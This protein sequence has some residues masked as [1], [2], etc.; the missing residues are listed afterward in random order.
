[1]SE[2]ITEQNRFSP[3]TGV[4]PTLEPLNVEIEDEKLL[5]YIKTLEEKAK[6][7]WDSE[8]VNL[9]KRRDQNFKYLFGKQLK[10]KRLK[11]YESEYIDNTIY[12]SEGILKSLALSKM[13][14]III[15][16][17]EF[18][19]E[20][21]KR[22]ADLLT[23]YNDNEINKLELKKQL[24]I[25]FKHLPVYLIS[26]MKYRWDESKGKF[27]SFIQEVVHPEHLLLDHTAL[28]ANPD[29]ME[30]VVQY[31]EKSGKE[32]AMLFPKKEQ[33][34]IDYIKGKHSGL[35]D[36][37][38]EVV[39][40][41]K[42]R[43]AEVWFD[44]FDKAED[45]DPEKPKFNF[46]SGVAWKLS[47]DVLLGKSKNPNWDYEGHSVATINGS[48][49]APE[50]IQQLILTGQQP[51]G[52][53]IKKVFNNYFDFPRKPFIFMSYDQFLM[54]AIDETSRIEQIVPIQ[55]SVDDTER[56]LD[57]MVRTSKGKNIFSK[58]SGMKAKDLEKL[59]LNDP[60]KDLLVNGV[61]SQVHSFIP[62]V[63]PPGEMFV[64]A[65]DKRDRIFAKMGV[66]GAT[67]GEVTTSTATTNQISREAD[68]NKSDDIVDETILHVVTELAKARLH[69]MKLR[70]TADHFKKILGAQGEDLHFQLTNDSIEDG[71]EVIVSAS[72]TDKLKAERNAQNMAQLN[73][74]DPLT[75]F[76]DLGLSD[77]EGR[78]ERLFLKETN[79][80]MY[81]QKYILK[82]DLK[83]IANTVIQ[84]QTIP[85]AGQ[86]QPMGQ[87]PVQPSP[88][89]T[90]NV[91]TQPQ[92]GQGMLGRAMGGIKNLFNR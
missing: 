51:E 52:F 20:Q 57:Y 38:D 59:D 6:L 49:V 60:D 24:G 13:P 86:P 82:K 1:M 19:N 79:P 53:E 15:N 26:A 2:T 48:P 25:M 29:E 77:P 5:G 75:Y 33:D 78:A 73:L 85:Q 58:D 4:I 90:G 14:D 30:F 47:N 11:K 28:S 55:K 41:Q 72:T 31:V 50:I 36:N 3:T 37:T 23:K 64:H 27:G 18:D 44:W 10:G 39:L 17:A 71:M 45:F 56:S 21:K 16:P 43:V 8:E 84:G 65:R 54:S 32:W 70:Y 74:I 67:R 88:Q 62:A 42:V 68:F 40:S 9:K 91:A 69:I 87:A 83:E 92:G 89:D 35:K 66:H 76:Q 80:E 34:I 12:E 22:V 61:P 63:M 7:H 46:M 81:Y